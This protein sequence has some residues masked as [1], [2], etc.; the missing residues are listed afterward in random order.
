MPPPTIFDNCLSRP[1]EPGLITM[2]L[3]ARKGAP[4]GGLSCPFGAIHL[5][6]ISWYGVQIRTVSQEIATPSARNDMVVGSCP[7]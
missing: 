6:A 2:S 3:R 5:L 1:E 7:S 4:Q